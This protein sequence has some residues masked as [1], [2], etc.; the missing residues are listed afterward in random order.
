VI[1]TGWYA[2]KGGTREKKMPEFLFKSSR[3]KLVGG[4]GGELSGRIYR[5]IG[6]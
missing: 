3:L 5:Y 4:G 6:E 2:K 1:I